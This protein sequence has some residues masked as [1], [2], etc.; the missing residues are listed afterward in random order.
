M[1]KFLLLAFLVTVFVVGFTGYLEYQVS[2]GRGTNQ[3]PQ[4][5]E[6]VSGV[7]VLELGKQLETK[8]IIS[9]QYA[10]AWEVATKRLSRKLIAGEYELSG[11][12]SI[13][14]I[15]VAFTSGKVVSHDVKVTFPEGFT[16]ELMADRLRGKGLPGD[17]FEKEAMKP[18]LAWRDKYPF[19][20]SI[21]QGGSLEGFLFPDTY[22]F[23]PDVSAMDIIE[24]MLDNFD[25]R[26]PE[27]LRADAAKK[28]AQ[29]YDALIVASIVEE[30]GNNK[31]NRGYIAGIFINR[32]KIGQPLQSDVTVN[33]ASGVHKQKLSLDDIDLDSKFNTYK[34]P[35]LPPTPITN[36]GLESITASIYPTESEY[37]Y[38]I[39]DPTNGQAYYARTFEEHVKNREARGL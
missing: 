2:S 4:T 12:E 30:E 34:Y 9:S 25:T 37:F 6:L 26:I 20:K 18:G 16:I 38:F 39:T 3:T 7:G 14:S 1:K 11:A 27:K 8:G 13:Q 32:L 10:F 28:H 22:H 17:D 24:T 29:F 15:L 23:A 36:P 21:P 35:G 19:L 5:F 33:Y 31:E